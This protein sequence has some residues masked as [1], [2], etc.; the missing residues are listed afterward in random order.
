MLNIY[1][2]WQN[3]QYTQNSHYGFFFLHTLPSANASNLNMH[4]SINFMLKYP[5]FR[6]RKVRFGSYLRHWRNVGGKWHQNWHHTVQKTSWQDSS[7]TPLHFL[8]TVSHVEIPVGYS[9]KGGSNVKVI[10]WYFLFTSICVTSVTYLHVKHWSS[11]FKLLQ[12]LQQANTKSQIL[13]NPQHFK[14]Q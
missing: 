4:Y 13:E 6:S 2:E 10:Q 7:Y 8:A 1:P 3:F 14:V 9:R 11:A 5:Y 12:D